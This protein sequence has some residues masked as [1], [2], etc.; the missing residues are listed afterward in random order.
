MSTA[1]FLLVLLAWAIGG[2]S[3]GPA[4]L[5]IAGTSMHQ[6]RSAGLAL[7]TGIIAGSAIWGITAALGM[8]ALMLANVW[9]VEVL[10]YLGAAYLL[11]LAFKAGKSAW[12][13]KPMAQAGA[14]QTSLKALFAKG[15]LIHLT[16]P[17]AIF[18]WGAMFAVV[19]PPTAQPLVVVETFAALITVSMIVFWGYGFLFS[20]ASAVRVYALSRRWFEGAFAVMFG[21]AGLK[22]LTAKLVP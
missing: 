22:I 2:A 8:S 5:A 13:N 15:L 17:K 6:G 7:A 12:L 11:F 20:S 14:Q 18:G 3:P 4:T 19:V 10:R 1:T 21:L 9:A 16:N